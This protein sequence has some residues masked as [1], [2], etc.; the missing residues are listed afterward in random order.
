MHT[1]LKKKQHFPEWCPV[2]IAE[3]IKEK[4]LALEREINEVMEREQQREERIRSRLRPDKENKDDAPLSEEKVHIKDSGR[5]SRKK[6]HDKKDGHGHRHSHGHKEAKKKQHEMQYDDG[7]EE[8]E[9]EE[10]DTSNIEL[11]DRTTVPPSGEEGKAA[12]VEAGKGAGEEEGV[13]QEATIPVKVDKVQESLD[14]GN[15]TDV[16]YEDEEPSEGEEENTV[17]NSDVLSTIPMPSE[18]PRGGESREEEGPREAGDLDRGRQEEREVVTVRL[19]QVGGAE[20]LDEQEMEMMEARRRQAVM[21][22]DGEDI[23][24]EPADE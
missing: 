2:N 15:N 21:A 22:E 16:D 9:E 19:A 8:M 4:D 7:E 17:T 13:E 20:G 18:E 5:E 23:E 24:D 10:E 1:W 3:M 6:S 11:G 14:D 12:R